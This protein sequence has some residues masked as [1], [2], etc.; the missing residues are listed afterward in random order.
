MAYARL[1]LRGDTAAAW[2]SANPVLASREIALE[3]DTHKFKVGDGSTAWNS[4]AYGGLQGPAGATGATGP[5]GSPGS[6]GAAATITVG[7]VTTGAAGSS[8]SV[9]NA[10]TSSAAVF[11]FSIPKGDKGDAGDPTSPTAVVEITATSATLALSHAQK[12][13]KCNNASAQTITIPAEATV[14]WPAGTEM[15]GFQYGAGAVTFVG[16][17]GVT[18]RK[19]SSLTLAALGQYA[20]FGLKKIGTNE[21]LLFGMMGSA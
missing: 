11:N 18:I 19:H 14:A 5:Q 13:L 12:W 6:A 2:S 10:G 1:Q 15:Q 9:S 17:S 8:A 4:L 7:T 3:T 20:P 16:A 21:W